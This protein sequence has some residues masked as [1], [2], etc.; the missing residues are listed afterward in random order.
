LIA[1][2]LLPDVEDKFSVNTNGSRE[3]RINI[4][5]LIKHIKTTGSH[6]EVESYFS[7]DHY[8][9]PTKEMAVLGTGSTMSA[10]FDDGL[11]KWLGNNIDRL[12]D[13]IKST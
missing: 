4:A 8:F 9:D 1:K 5:A 10:A 6:F 2:Y 11:E 7:L 12:M 13:A 3:R